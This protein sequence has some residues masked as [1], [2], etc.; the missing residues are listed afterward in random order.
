MLGPASLSFTLGSLGGR[1][2]LSDG[3]ALV[4]PREITRL[5]TPSRRDAGAERFG[6]ASFRLYPEA[7]VLYSASAGALLDNAATPHSF[8]MKRAK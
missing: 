2:A 7:A 1:L 4:F 8:R 3:E 6:A 5:A